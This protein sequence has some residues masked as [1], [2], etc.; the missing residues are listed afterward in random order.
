MHYYDL[1]I[2]VFL[3]I[4]FAYGFSRGFINMIF[5][6][7]AVVFGLVLGV[8]LGKLVVGWLPQAYRQVWFWVVFVVVFTGGYFGV[9][10]FSYWLEDVLEFFELEWLDSLL[11]GVVGLFQFGFLV[12]L[13]FL[14]VERFPFFPQDWIQKEL[15]LG[16]LLAQ[17]TQVVINVFTHL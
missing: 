4:G 12:G 16:L 7:L 17:W 5:T 13:I 2:V 3:I 9:K 10:R 15:P 1:F 6:L 11:G 14:L 8:A